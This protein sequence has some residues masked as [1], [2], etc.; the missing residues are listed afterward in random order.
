VSGGRQRDRETEREERD[1]ERQRETEGD[2]REK[3][4]D[5]R[6]RQKETEAERIDKSLRDAR[7]MFKQ[8]EKEDRWIYVYMNSIERLPVVPCYCALGLR[9][10]RVHLSHPLQINF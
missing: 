1:R 4:R 2:E 3:E 6:E 5:E 10:T 9:S 8:K 7:H